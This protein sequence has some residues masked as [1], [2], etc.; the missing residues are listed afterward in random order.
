KNNKYPLLFMI[1]FMMTHLSQ[2]T[3]KGCMLSMQNHWSNTPLKNCTLAFAL[4]MLM[5]S[6]L[7]TSKENP[8]ESQSVVEQVLITLRFYA[9]GT[10]CQIV[11]DNIGVDKSTVSDVVK[12]VSV[13]LASLVNQSVSLP[14]DDQIAQ[15]KHKLFLLGNMPNTIGRDWEY[16]NRKG[17][18]SINIQL[19]GDADLIITNCVVKWPGSVYDARILRES[20]LYRELQTNRPDGTMLGDSACPLL[21][22]LITPFLTATAPAQ[23]CF[24]TAHAAFKWSSEETACHI[25]PACISLH[26]IATRH[27]VPFCDDVYDEP[28][29]VEEP[30]QPLVFCQDEG[31][32]GCVVRD[33]TVRNYF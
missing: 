7:K 31:L 28:E 3:V 14:K 8:K 17:R 12:A 11:G 30:D 26:N 1:Y 21:P 15:N 10:I 5:L 13:A 23:A 9:S 6:T 27:N 20:A 33:G 25:I 32:T 22:R 24:N 18:C 19:L 4:G 16:I 2:D 29:P